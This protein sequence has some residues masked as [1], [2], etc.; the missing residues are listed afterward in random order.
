MLIIPISFSLGDQTMCR[1]LYT[2]KAVLMLHKQHDIHHLW[3]L[4]HYNAS[5][6]HLKNTANIEFSPFSFNS[7]SKDWIYKLNMCVC[8]CV[9]VC[10]CSCIHTH[11]HT[12]NLY[13]I[14]NM[15]MYVR[16][17]LSELFLC[18]AIFIWELKKITYFYTLKYK[19]NIFLVISISLD[20]FLTV[21][22]ISNFISSLHLTL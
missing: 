16:V 3:L 15:Y 21:F 11:T 20:I 9:C 6:T 12:H 1:T 22:L 17:Y 14:S 7:A 13:I 2:G 8:V 10:V 19:C 18:M 4:G 5:M